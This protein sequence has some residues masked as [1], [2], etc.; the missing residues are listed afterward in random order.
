VPKRVLPSRRMLPLSSRSFS[1]LAAL[2]KLAPL[3]GF[4]MNFRRSRAAVEN[5]PWG[6]ARVGKTHPLAG[7]A[8]FQLVLLHPV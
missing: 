7:A 5:A 1:L 6:I 3:L 4:G 2:L 8:G